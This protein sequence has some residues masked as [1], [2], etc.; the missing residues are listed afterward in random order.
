MHFFVQVK[1]LL[2][3]C[4]L[5]FQ[6]NVTGNWYFKMN[7]KQFHQKDVQ[8]IPWVISDSDF[9]KV[10]ALPAKIDL[11]KTIYVG[12]LHGMLNA[13]GLAKIMGDLFG[14]VIHAGKRSLTFSLFECEHYNIFSS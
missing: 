7:S 8:V 4:F 2:R 3:S 1:V 9:S 6:K 10:P 13:E 5:D 11:K 14:G 12:A